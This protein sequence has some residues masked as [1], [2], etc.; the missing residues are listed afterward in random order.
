MPSL[1]VLFD[2]YEHLLLLSSAVARFCVLKR[3][4]LEQEGYIRIRVE[5]IGGGLLEISEFWREAASQLDRLEYAYHWQ[6]ANGQIVCRWDNVKHYP[7][8][9]NAPH[10]VHQPDGQVSSLVEPINLI[11][12]LRRIEEH[13]GKL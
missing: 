10:H 12:V 6:N 3:R 13:V 9:P 2:E 1:D 5:I 7:E 11:L 8:L 4:V